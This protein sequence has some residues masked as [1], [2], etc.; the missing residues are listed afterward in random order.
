MQKTPS[1][2][3][4]TLIARLARLGRRQSVLGYVERLEP[5]AIEGWALERRLRPLRL[6]VQIKQERYGL[7]PTWKERADVAGERGEAFLYAGFFCE[8]SEELAK[9]LIAAQQG[10]HPVTVFAN[11]IALKSPEH[12]GLPA[13]KPATL[14][15]D[16]KTPLKGPILLP[17][18]V[19]DSLDDAAA[20][21]DSQPP[22]TITG[23]SRIARSEHLS[24]GPMASAASFDL[25][26]AMLRQQCDLGH[27]T[28]VMTILDDPAYLQY[29]R[30]PCLELELLRVLAQIGSRQW[31]ALNGERLL[32]AFLDDFHSTPVNETLA[33][34]RERVNAILR[35]LYRHLAATL[36]SADAA[37]DI[38]ADSVLSRL[39][40]PLAH[41]THRITQDAYLALDFVDLLMSGAH[42]IDSVHWLF[43]VRL[44]RLTGRDAKALSLLNEHW[45][46]HTDDWYAWHELGVLTRLYIRGHYGL[47]QAQVTHAIDA[48]QQ[49]KT[50][51]PH[52]TL[53]QREGRGLLREYFDNLVVTTRHLAESGDI[54]AG[55]DQRQRNLMLLARLSLKLQ[56]EPHGMP[57]RWSAINTQKILFWGSRD[58]F[59][60][61]YYR[62]REKVEQAT[63]LGWETDVLD[64]SEMPFADWRRRLMGA[65]VLYA[66]RV[67]ACAA[68]LE[69]FAY[70]RHLGIPIIYDIDDLIFDPD[71]FP[72]ALATYAGSIDAEQHRHLML[73]N[74]FFSTALALSDHCSVSTRPLA[75]EA[76]RY[77]TD[78]TEIT[79]LPNLMSEEI[80]ARASK[81]TPRRTR[82]KGDETINL[83]Y[84]SATKAHKQAFYDL[85][86]PAAIEV[87]KQSPQVSLHLVGYFDQLPIAF[88]GAGR[89]KLIDP[90]SDYLAYMDL[91]EQ[92]DINVAVLE[93]SRVTD[94]KSEI[95]WLEA[96]AFG[97]PSVLS[98][99][100]AYRQVLTDG[101]TALF[102]ATVDEWKRQLAR[103]IEDAGLRA[104][105]GRA[106]RQLALER[107]SPNVG[108]RILEGILA[109][110]RPTSVVRAKKRLLFANVY[111]HPQ[112]V[113][114][115]TR[116][117]ETQV[118]GL[119]EHYADEYDVFVLTTQAD[120]DPARP[121]GVDQ[122]WYG[123]AL[124][125]R[126]EIPS[127]DWSTHED[128][129]IQAFCEDFFRLYDFDLIHLHSIQMLTTSVAMAALTCKIPY[130][131]TLHDAWWLSRYLF[132]VDED[133]QLV[134]HTDPLSGGAPPPRGPSINQ[135]LARSGTLHTVLKK[136]AGVLAVSDSF[137]A[138]YR[139]AGVSHVQTHE[140]L[141]EPFVP[142]PRAPRKDDRL[143]LGFIGGISRH[144]GYH[145]LREAI[146]SGEFS[147]FSLLIVD[148]ALQSGEFYDAHWGKT[149]V[150]YI[151]KVEQSQVAHLYA[152]MDVLIA[153]SIWPESYGLIT[154]EALQAGLWV[155][156]SDRGAIG[157][158]V[159]EGVNGNLVDVSDYRGLQKVLE[160]LP[161]ALQ[162]RVTPVLDAMKEHINIRPQY[163]K[164]LADIYRAAMKNCNYSHL[165]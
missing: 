164:A 8:P 132:L 110:Y 18:D 59:Q 98:P 153:P 24:S 138:L 88:I 123:A 161:D 26:I 80:F 78:G 70:A 29:V 146:E 162:Q 61:F 12:P 60:C 75:D 141:P 3:S 89:I 97:I 151:S 115:A 155:I 165:M 36:A 128:S 79:V 67:P 117:M 50:H 152:Q 99:T 44:H 148:H 114:G 157:D 85:F 86:L 5:W 122:Y 130:I 137:V 54:A 142:M 82:V 134:D 106:A 33:A 147:D 43:I 77:L 4:A 31:S 74:P 9:A 22:H 129:K 56:G 14:P 125:T 69:L 27:L 143:V 38:K 53:S 68:E 41:W 76:A 7:K 144:K 83:F 131:V 40:L 136:A 71:F 6:E 111:F 16:D 64:L 127:R 42:A 55:V 107:F 93:T 102:A 124:V 154:R 121:Y 116:V 135:R 95:K 10:G 91:V 133:G 145:L 126:V 81:P 149:P 63:A 159:V 92:A 90:T 37:E 112:A 34:H 101:E 73:D 15:V 65:A 94:V 13:P 11:G 21:I 118:R 108:E 30:L 49:A 57:R 17:K 39:A 120:P 87:L 109:P 160:Q 96:A 52:Q 113:G 2:P 150:R 84:G 19:L 119:L 48:F 139:E 156:A 28:E 66:C 23:A 25:L 1:R 51:N 158:C 103:L 47:L 46:A 163:L 20:V 72:P 45:H 105:I 62:V 32:A 100:A 140:N 58:L 35:D 104:R